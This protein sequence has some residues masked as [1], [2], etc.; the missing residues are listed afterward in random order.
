MY[1]PYIGIRSY[2]TIVLICYIFMKFFNKHL[3]DAVIQWLIN[4]NTFYK[5]DAY[6][7]IKLYYF[8]CL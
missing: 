1:W 8:L 5:V 4:N 3:Y 7:Y 6:I 2:F